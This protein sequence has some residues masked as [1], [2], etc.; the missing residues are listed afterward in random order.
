MRSLWVMILVPWILTAYT[1][2]EM[3]AEPRIILLED[4]LSSSECDYLIEGA[5]P[6]LRRSRVLGHQGELLDDRRTSWGMFF[7]QLP[8]D[9][10]LS[11]IEVRIASFVNLP[12]ENGEGIQVLW[13]REGGE[14]QPHY[15]YFD[16][17]VPGGV[18]RGGQRV[19]TVIMYLHDTE[20]GGETI[21]PKVNI[22]IKPVKGNA[23]LFYNCAPDGRE[24][25]LTLHGG[26]PVKKGEKWI[27]TKWI[28]SGVFR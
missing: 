11:G 14:Y 3:S 1:I 9:P 18:D 22:K 8:S 5:R 24:D 12:R 19:A 4:F 27:A 10:I 21:F 17:K 2:R 28:R 16:P 25:P 7:P 13:Y 6:H 20:E 15:D 26:A 23:V